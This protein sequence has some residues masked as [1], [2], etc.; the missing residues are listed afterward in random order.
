MWIPYGFH[1]VHLDFKHKHF[2]SVI[3]SG[4]HTDSMDSMQII[5]ENLFLDSTWNEP[6]MRMDSTRIPQGFHAFWSE[7]FLFGTFYLES[8]WN[9]HGLHGVCLDSTRKRGGG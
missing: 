8:M 7:N 9:P 5:T 2:L 1:A 3:L 4:I 6:G